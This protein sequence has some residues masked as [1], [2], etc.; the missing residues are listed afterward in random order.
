MTL[1]RIAPGESASAFCGQ[2]P[3]DKPPITTTH[4]RPHTGWITTRWKRR[5]AVRGTR[6][7][8]SYR[9]AVGSLDATCFDAEASGRGRAG[10]L[11]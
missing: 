4:Q 1:A 11:V 2:P 5:V 9:G 8:S 6:S 3:L 7:S 10:T